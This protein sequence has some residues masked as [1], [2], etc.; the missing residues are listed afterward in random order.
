LVKNS[1]AQA[2][3]SCATEA[4]IVQVL[5]ADLHPQF[6]Y[7]SINLHVLEREGW[8]HSVAIDKG[9]LQDIR[10][11]Q[12]AESNFGHYYQDPRTT[13]HDPVDSSTYEQSRGPASGRRPALAIWVPIMHRDQAI[14]AVTYQALKNRPVPP[15]EIELLEEIHRPLGVLVSNAYL[16]EVTRNQSVRLSALNA[17]ARA[18]SSTLDEKGVLAELYSTLTP[19]LPVDVLELVAVDEAD[20]RRVRVLRHDAA[21]E[22]LSLTLPLRSKQIEGA[23]QVLRSGRSHL[24]GSSNGTA[25]IHESGAWVPIIEGDRVRG[26]LSIHSK[27]VD[28][29]EQSTLTFLEQVADEVALAV[30]NAWSYAAIE[31]QRRRLEVVNA[32]GRRLASS[33]DRWSIMRTLR[34]ELSRHLDFDL[35][36]LATVSETDSGPVAEGYVYDSGVEQPLP[37]LALATAGPSRE[38]YETGQP[39]LL[40]RNPWAR[41]FEASEVGP[42]GVV[43]AEGAV[44]TVTRPGGKNSRMATRSVLWVPVRHG[45][46]ISALLSLQSY[47]PEAFNDWHVQLL[48]D[49]A[50]HVS[51]ALANA[52]HFAAAQAERRRLEALHVLELGVAGSADEHQIAE[53]VFQAAQDYISASH[54]VLAYLDAQGQL[55]GFDSELGGPAMPL[56]PKP[57]ESTQFFRRLVDSGRTIAERVPE[58]LRRPGQGVGWTTGD[59]RLPSQVV[60]VPVFQNDRVIGAISAQRYEDQP[61]T[62]DDIQLLDSA[63]PVVGIALRTVRLHRANELALAHSVRIQEVAALAGHDLKSVVASVA[64]QARTMLEATGVCCW[65]FDD[66]LRVTAT[67]ASGDA[68]AQKV[69]AW[70]QRAG[71][72]QKD[73]PNIITGTAKDVPWSLIPLWYA[74]RLVGALGSVHMPGA[75]EEPGQTAPLDFARHA[76]I[77]IENA[78]LVAETRGRIHT[79][80]AVAAFADLDI[81][82]PSGTRAEMAMLVE[83][84]LAASNGALWLRE[85]HELVR[86]GDE[87]NR[88]SLSHV[89]KITDTRHPVSDRRL[90]SLI[91]PVSGSDTEVYAT[92]ISVDGEVAGMLTADAGGAS[93]GETRR[94]MS[95]LAGQSGVVL[96]RL[97]LVDAL[98][99][100]RQMMN[101]ILRHSPVGVILE[102]AAGRVV[103]A[104][105]EV[106]QIYGVPAD[107]MTGVSAAQILAESGAVV[108]PEVEP[109]PGVDLE[110]RLQSSGRVIEVRR[111]PIPGAADQPAG[112]LTIH[113][114]VTREREVLEAKD[115]MLRAIG[116]EVRS[117]AAAMKSTLAGVLQWDSIMDATQR[118][119]LLEEAY[120]M[121]DRL[122]SLVEGQLIIAKLETHRFEPNPAPVALGT[123]LEQVMAV[124]RHRYG[125]LT[126][127]VEV[128]LRADLPPAYCEPTHL[129]QV[130]TNLIG[131][132]LEYTQA[133]VEVTARVRS[134]WLEVTVADDGPGLP[135]ERVGSL[136]QKT[137]PA[138]QNRAR[139][140]LGLGLY[141]CRLV[142]E[143]SFGGRIWLVETDRRGTTF[144]FT[145]PAAAAPARGAV[146]AE[147]ARS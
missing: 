110:L 117:P 22:G 50:A 38:A 104:N 144:K 62:S 102:D 81:T 85:G 59:G 106:E 45:D 75:V 48:Q 111:V 28:A 138:G 13:I 122:L 52:E 20:E 60:W 11:R 114:D 94:L 9:V 109:G 4:D 97:Q 74:D 95:V 125:P 80:E 118:R 119:G 129:N 46:R 84:A 34:E 47:R 56:E 120:E 69:M 14:G 126:E 87:A 18:L 72:W 86:V 115:L 33:L 26:A 143:R 54:L 25:H 88:L 32:V 93:P 83:R 43:I 70:S 78:R 42:G 15:E 105:P 98:D 16:N 146:R 37:A 66:E 51:L 65:A 112:V 79:L 64:D 29:Y 41:S 55:T 136:F 141:L 68:V 124:L 6:G 8:Y 31:A 63:A 139:G 35:F 7:D 142:V 123:A 101:A 57:I 116:H 39:V 96:G 140:G 36:A 49:V 130:L 100:E 131:N 61:F 5:Y 19:L 24:R 3:A 128:Q 71:D 91:Q 67:A 137:G 10:R 2:L 89:D 82:Q 53:A 108:A 145:V 12:L 121:S 135:P 134:G 40:K 92:P 133:R 27:Q 127:G 77:A 103:Y 132:A 44:M 107:S 23:R 113:E 17:I 58:E 21:G 99:R 147:A 73:R 30:R 90:K 76:A 1:L